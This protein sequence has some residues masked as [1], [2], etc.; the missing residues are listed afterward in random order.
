[1]SIKRTY[2]IVL[3][4]LCILSILLSFSFAKS[5]TIAK[6]IQEVN[7]IPPLVQQKL[8]EKLDKFKNTI[9]EKCKL[10]TIEA[11]E[12]FVDSLV[13]EQLKLQVNDPISFPAKP[14]RPELL[15]KIILNDSTVIDPIF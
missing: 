2:K 3:G 8:K 4:V 6:N 14:V 7:A 11:A 10:E 15:K 5:D 9:L 13:S 1:M 12:I